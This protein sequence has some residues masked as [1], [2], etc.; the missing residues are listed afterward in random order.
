MSVSGL[1]QYRATNKKQTEQRRIA[2]S[3]C[4][5]LETHEPSLLF[6]FIRGFLRFLCLFAALPIFPQLL[7]CALGD[8]KSAVT[9]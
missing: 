1:L 5:L 2:M 6:A 4:V 9:S 7:D 8:G 3:E